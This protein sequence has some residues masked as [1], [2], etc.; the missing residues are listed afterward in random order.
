MGTKVHGVKASGGVSASR[1]VITL[2]ACWLINLALARVPPPSILYGGII[3]TGGDVAVFT[4]FDLHVAGAGLVS[5]SIN[6]GAT[7]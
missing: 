2:S 1:I 7:R 6:A 5:G 4:L 3:I